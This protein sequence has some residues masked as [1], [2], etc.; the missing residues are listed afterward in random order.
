MKKFKNLTIQDD[1]MFSKAMTANL[2][3]T[4]KVIELITGRK[5]EDVKFHKSQYA[6]NS[7][8][9]AKGARFDVLLEGD[10]VRYD[11]EMQVKKQNDLVERNLYY[12]SMLVVESLKEGRSYK[13]IPHIFTIFICIFDPFNEGEE[14]YVIKE[15]VVSRGKDITDKIHYEC[16]YDKIYLNAGLIKPNHTE[17]NKELTNFLEYIRSNIALDK[18]TEEIDDLVEEAKISPE[19]ELEYM[20]LEEKLKMY[21]AEGIAEGEKKKAIET[22]RNLLLMTDFSIDKI[23]E[24]TLLPVEEIEKLKQK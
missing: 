11:I 6:V 5:V 9:E 13:E 17:G 19:M 18:L 10:D 23:S 20:T 22:A 24:I 16:G 8:V 2:E 1:F 3:L 4:K 12:T 14:K 21:K 7:F 15:N